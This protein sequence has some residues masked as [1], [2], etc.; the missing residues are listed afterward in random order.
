MAG[1]PSAVGSNRR[2]S[3]TQ[4]RTA[5]S[6]SGAQMIGGGASKAGT[7]C[8]A[9]SEWAPAAGLVPRDWE[10]PGARIGRHP[11]AAAGG[12]QSFLSV[13]EKMD[14][15]AAAALPTFVTYVPRPAPTLPVAHRP[16]SQ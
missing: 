15:D 9:R 7:E 12:G 11:Y 4:G 10:G 16:P 3:A 13:D 14:K 8:A 2:W 5:F 6:L 1:I